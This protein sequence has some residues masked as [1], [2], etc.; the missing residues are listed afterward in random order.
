MISTLATLDASQVEALS[1]VGDWLSR[2]RR[3]PKV[4]QVFRLGG[5]AGSGKTTV[6][7]EIVEQHRDD[8][9]IIVTTL[10][11]KA[12]AVLRDKGLHDA[13]NLHQVIYAPNA[14]VLAERD[15]LLADMRATTDPGHA[16]TLRRELDELG[17][18]MFSRREALD[19]DLIIVDEAS[20]IS[21]QT[22]E[23]LRRY[24]VPI[25]AVGDPGQLP[26]V[27]RS[28][29]LL[30]P[31]FA[32]QVPDVVLVT[33]HR[34]AGQEA[35]ERAAY[36]ARQG[37][38]LPADVMVTDP[39][40]TAYDVVLVWRN[41]ARVDLLQ[42]R[43]EALG[44]PVDRPVPG[45]VVMVWRNDH[46]R[47]VFNGSTFTVDQVEEGDDDHA[48]AWFVRTTTG[49]YLD[50]YKGGFRTA[51][52]LDD[53]SRLATKRLTAVVATFGDVV[54]VHKAQGSEWPRVLVIDHPTK[55]M[56]NDDQRRWRYTA[57]TRASGLVHVSG[58]QFGESR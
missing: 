48:D 30:P 1:K 36:A 13:V 40:L 50:V 46:A 3:D 58:P 52:E 32:A 34:S 47:G 54:T 44:R 9:N 19:A 22:A 24:G 49:E 45:D 16:R 7:R 26:P 41:A 55:V 33:N 5:H 6:I 27:D 28:E 42:R 31:L 29:H 38:A 53:L 56:S 4:P 18:R 39:D 20:M 17:P 11:G 21:G 8:L 14:D 35:I 57:V 12:A 10:A 25:L 23:D 15:R 51:G 2:R 37:M 43:R